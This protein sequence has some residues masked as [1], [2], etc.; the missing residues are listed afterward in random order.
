M[1]HLSQLHI[2]I[3]MLA[4][5]GCSAATPTDVVASQEPVVAADLGPARHVSPTASEG[6]EAT[7]QPMPKLEVASAGSSMAH[8]NMPGM[9]AAPV[10]KAHDGHNDAHGTGT[11]NS[12]NAA[13]HSIN[14]SHKP[15]PSIG[16]PAMTMDFKA[17]PSVDL[18]QIKPG[19]TVNFTIE[20]GKD[21]M[22]EVQAL[23]P[24]AAAK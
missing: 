4:L 18:S 3:A 12:V 16:W 11:I 21:G 15:I 19:Q 20:Q 23:S 10:Q 5:T 22:Y 8:M 14:I 1:S 6:H 24:A 13:Q 2:A 7:P 9:T 17:A